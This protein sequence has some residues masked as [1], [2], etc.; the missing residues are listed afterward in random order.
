MKLDEYHCL[1]ITG[2]LLWGTVALAQSPGSASGSTQRGSTSSSQQRN[3]TA[4]QEGN[5]GMQKS[6]SQGVSAET[7]IK[8]ASQDGLTEVQLASLAQKKSQSEDVRKFAGQMQTDHGKANSELESIAA[9]RH[10]TVSTALDSEH[11]AML[12]ELNGKNG[13]AFDAAYADHMVAAHNKAV[14]LFKSG[15]QSQ[16][17]DISGFAAKTLPTL[18]HHKGMADELA[19]KRKMASA[20][21]P[22]ATS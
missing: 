16:D 5:S 2:A 13:S 9:S 18:E 7:F 11:Q 1:L 22:G 3:L 4:G 6:D 10:I 21:A 19:A 8:K 20:G 12:T 17:Q 14:A 15:A